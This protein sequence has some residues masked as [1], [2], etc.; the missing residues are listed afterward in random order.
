LNFQHSVYSIKMGV[1]IKMIW[2]VS[3]FRVVNNHLVKSITVDA[4]EMRLRSAPRCFSAFT[5]ELISI[6]KSMAR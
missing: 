2:Y 1:V 5:E 6:Y 4:Y 3:V